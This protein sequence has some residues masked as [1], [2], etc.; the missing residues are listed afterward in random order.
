MISI[1]IDIVL[2]VQELADAL[3]I[4]FLETSVTNSINI[5]EVFTTITTQIMS[6]IRS[7]SSKST[8]KPYTKS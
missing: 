1:D 5:E 2:L 8:H 3:N 6:R 4:P 7:H